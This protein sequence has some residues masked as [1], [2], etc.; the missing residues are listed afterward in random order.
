[1][2]CRSSSVDVPTVAR[3]EWL[4]ALVIVVCNRR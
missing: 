1:M 4:L 3:G 2:A